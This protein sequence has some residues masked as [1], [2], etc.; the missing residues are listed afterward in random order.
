MEI[1]IS[2][3]GVFRFNNR[4]IAIYKIVFILL[5]WRSH[6]DREH[7]MKNQIC[8]IG[9]YHDMSRKICFK[10]SDSL[11]CIL[12]LYLTDN[13]DVKSAAIKV[14]FTNNQLIQIYGCYIDKKWWCVI[15]CFSYLWWCKY[16]LKVI[17]DHSV[18]N[19][20]VFLVSK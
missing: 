16:H 9:C 19:T 17:I 15:F 13:A 14:H 8:N 18:D 12:C 2:R 10:C 11:P 3:A 20:L 7:L 1:F 6:L 4:L 5:V